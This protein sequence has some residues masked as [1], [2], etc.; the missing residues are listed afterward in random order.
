[1]ATGKCEYCGR[2]RENNPGD[3]YHEKDCE[4][5]HCTREI[6]KLK[7]IIAFDQAKV[8]RLEKQREMAYYVGD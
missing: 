8:K 7:A 3:Y 6:G 5:K 4:A 2:V 1:M